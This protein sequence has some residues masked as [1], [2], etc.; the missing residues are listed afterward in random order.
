LV[1]HNNDLR[2]VEVPTITIAVEAIGTTEGGD[3]RQPK[4]AHGDGAWLALGDEDERSASFK[5]LLCLMEAIRHH[6][7]SHILGAAA[8]DQAVLPDLAVAL[9]IV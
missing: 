8:F 5:G 1:R 4:A 9:A 3:S 2:R 6:L 7:V